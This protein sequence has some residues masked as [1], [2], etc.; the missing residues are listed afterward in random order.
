MH[1][2]KL[3]LILITSLLLLSLDLVGQRS[4][5]RN[6]SVDDGLPSSEI[7]HVIQSKK[8]YIWVATNMG[9]SR[10]DGKTFKNYD[11]QDG[12]PENTVFEIYED[13][14]GRI[15]FIT[16]P[17][18]LAY[19]E[20]GILVPY[21]NNHLLSEFAGKGLVPLKQS[22]MVNDNKDIL[23]SF[24]GDG[25]IYKMSDSGK[26]EIY[27][28]INPD[29]ISVSILEYN[30]H[31][32][33]A[34]KGM[35]QA[36]QFILSVE[37]KKLK[38][39]L[40]IDESKSE[41]SHANTIMRTTRDGSL[42]FIRND[43]LTHVKTSGT[44]S[45]YKMNDRI[46]WMS[47]DNDRFIWVGK[48]VTGIQ[49]Y[50]INN[51][52][53]GPV[54]S[55]LEGTAVS[56]VLVDN[57][58]GTWFSSLNSGLFY[59]SS[60]AFT[61]YSRDEGISGKNVLTI[62][63]FKGKL[64]IGSDGG[65]LD[66]L[67]NGI[68]RNIKNEYFNN[69]AIN[70]LSAFDDKNLWISTKT[71]I[72]SF[73]NNRLQRFTN[74]H[75]FYLGQQDRTNFV[76]SIKDLYPLSDDKIMVGQMQSLSL[77]DRSKVTYD[78]YIDD[79]VE[80]RVESIAKET[81]ESYLLGT[82]NGLYRRI[83]EKIEYIGSSSPLLQERIT[84]IVVIEDGN[85]VIIGTKGFGLVVKQK[86][87]VF[88]IT[89]NDGLSSNSV[90]SIL[91]T[92][93]ELWVATNNGLN[94]L[95]INEIVLGKPKV[96]VFKKEHGLISNEINQVK[97]DSSIIYMASNGGLTIFDRKKYLPLNTHPPIYIQGIK[98]NKQ[99]TL[100]KADYKLGYQQNFITISYSGINF[101]DPGNLSY[102]YRL[103][104]L[105][106]EWISTNN[107][108]VEYAFLPH[109]RYTFEVYAI[110]SDGLSSL[111]PAII[112]FTIYPPF[113]K[114]W[115]F[116]ITVTIL[117]ILLL[118][119]II[120][121]RVRRIKKEHNLKNDIYKYRQQALIRQMDPHFVFNTLNSINAFIIK[122]DRVASSYYLTKFSKLMRLI[123][124]NSQKQEVALMDEIDALNLYMQL[125][126]MRFN[127]KFEYKIDYDNC[128]EAE[129]CRIPA[130]M[131]QPFVE[132][133]IWHGVM[134]L[135]RPGLIKV[136][137]IRNSEHITCNIEDNGIGRVKA[138][139]LKS[140]MS[141]KSLGIS[142]V[143][144]RLHLLS[145]YYGVKLNLKFTDLYNPDKTAAGTRVTLDLPIF[146]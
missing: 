97:G 117:T 37:T 96:I 3:T 84:D 75:D 15:W 24:L 30:S 57:E 81:E 103:L 108:Q 23:F 42:F 146:Y 72:Y 125:E 101:R 32:L 89:H 49:K 74:N 5:L 136:N 130:F 82:F 44:Y 93:N 69:K 83:G 51:I 60:K 13:S 63:K 40:Y 132:N 73:D 58:G 95:K 112:N 17:F 121:E 111:E 35:K 8:G 6:Y 2:N 61:T 19:I 79:K 28:D 45:S 113:W 7:F 67:E 59:L 71:H 10:F 76:F 25:K 123:L 88:N 128:L 141:K 53:A 39:R 9:V 80:I 12:L 129:I 48:E 65:S 87:K 18:Q 100:I 64:F 16:F 29:S 135:D 78:S 139:S 52:S 142:I 140:D 66:Y 56:S 127:N 27:R 22:F 102:K 50:D 31:L 46:L 122:N 138:M 70:V 99:D 41:F 134:N 4:V 90:T 34:Q 120:L 14:G 119:I 38:T 124:N 110:N 145:S 143:E 109:G 94:L 33:A 43:I 144:T 98:I 116:I 133:A 126:T 55:Y 137:F 106:K 104:G 114:T 62:E 68:I 105:S 131:I 47:V 77:I 86:G 1:Y 91:V 26:L 92:G 85:L 115:V 21:K 11:V 20:N 118:F 36:K 54:E 107:L